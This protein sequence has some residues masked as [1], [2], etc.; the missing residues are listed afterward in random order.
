MVLDRVEGW[1]FPVLMNVDVGHT[2]PMLTIPLNAM[3]S[4]DSSRDEFCILE[5][6]VV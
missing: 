6:N 1:D 2:S 4:L 5:S 3:S